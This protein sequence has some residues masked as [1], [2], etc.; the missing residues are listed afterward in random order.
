MS[1]WSKEN[2]TILTWKQNVF[3]DFLQGEKIEKT[4][5]LEENTILEYIII[6]DSSEWK[7]TINHKGN[8]AKSTVKVLSLGWTQNTTNLMI[9]SN[10]LAPHSQTDLHLISLLPRKNQTKIQWG[11]MIAKNCP[12]S[13]GYLLEECILLWD[14]VKLWT[15]PLL[16]VQSNDVKAS[17]GAKVH[18]LNDQELFYL[19]SKGIPKSLA[20]T[21]II[22]GIIENMIWQISLDKQQQTELLDRIINT[23]SY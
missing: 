7:I 11:I 10:I 8:N 18:R 21:L 2:M 15:A 16:D 6:C 22:N 23:I 19:T 17:H 5:D 9:Q 20:R 4:R 14:S 12:K 1:H 3:V 13:E